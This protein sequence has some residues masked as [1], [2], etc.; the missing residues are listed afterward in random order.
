MEGG[1]NA[2]ASSSTTTSTSTTSTTT[3]TTTTTTTN[4]SIT[5]STTTARVDANAHAD[6]L[7]VSAKDA[8]LSSGDT[9]MDVDI[10]DDRVQGTEELETEGDAEDDQESETEPVIDIEH[11]RLVLAIIKVRLYIC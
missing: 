9:A 8:A 7:T 4:P 3:T 2:T 11:Q 10:A 1:G 6:A 5:T